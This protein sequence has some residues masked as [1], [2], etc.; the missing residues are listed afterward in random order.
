MKKS[1]WV[2]KVA[3]IA[4]MVVVGVLVFGYVVMS[5]WNNILI[6]VVP[7]IHAVTFVQALG[8]LVLSKILFGGFR[9]GGGWKGRGGPWGHKM[10]E[11]WAAMTPEEQEKI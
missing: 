2:K 9:G 11:K 3:G 8:I 4:L 7:A 6:A 5:L 1:F 10:R